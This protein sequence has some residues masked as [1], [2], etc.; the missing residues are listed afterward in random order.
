M[1]RHNKRPI[2]LLSKF[3]KVPIEE[4]KPFY[5]NSVTRRTEQAHSSG[6]YLRRKLDS[7]DSVRRFAIKQKAFQDTIN[8]VLGDGWF[9]TDKLG[10]LKH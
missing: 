6:K 2:G 10:R 4:R 5:D 8:F 1:I 7:N 9:E 3:P